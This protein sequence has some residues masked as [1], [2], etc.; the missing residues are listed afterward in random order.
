MRTNGY[1]HVV[2]CEHESHTRV[3]VHVL[4]ANAF[5]GSRPSGHVVNHLDGNRIN[6]H[7]DNIEWTIQSE[8]VKHAYRNNLRVI[9]DAH[10]RRCAKLGLSKRKLSFGQV[11]QLK[12]GYA[13][14]RGD[15]TRLAAEYGIDRKGVSWIIKGKA[16]KE[17]AI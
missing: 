1:N 16:Y 17:A 9:D 14:K 12:A 5:H 13:G 10:K 11:A 6:N 7:K 8:N 15:I 4:V 2:L 3:G